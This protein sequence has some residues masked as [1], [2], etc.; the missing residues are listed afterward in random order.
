MSR[1]PTTIHSARPPHPDPHVLYEASVQGVE[2][3]LDFI[4]R[5][6]R[7]RH[8]RSFT[9]LRE[10]FCGTGLLAS[11]WALSGRTHLAWGRDLD[12]ATLAWSRRHR[13]A[14]LPRTVARRVI[15]ERKDVRAPGGPRVDVV[16][17]LNFSYWVFKTRDTLRD[18]FH[19]AR[20]ALRPG[21]LLVTNTFG[22]TEAM[23]TL[24]ET[25][26][27]PA[28][29]SIDGERVPAFTYVWDQ[30]SFNPVDHHLVCH[31]HF[32]LKDG[33][34]IRRA[35]TYD[36]RFW[37]LPELREIMAE[38]GFARCEVHVETWDEKRNRPGDDYVRRTRFENQEGW[39]AYVVGI[40]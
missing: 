2:F 33:R 25:R 37:T 15:L 23:D 4:E 36:W 30:A 39:L 24:I 27:I 6:Y 32:R 38:A 3:D 11:Q 29:Q 31:I 20:R 35:F 10:D 34:T 13:L 5:L 8:G 22:G 14:R 40:A 19:S 16:V 7:R 1:R 9:R 17:A 28:S 21:G 12:A 26:R 18:Y